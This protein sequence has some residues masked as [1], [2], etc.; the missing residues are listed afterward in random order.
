MNNFFSR[1]KQAFSLP[2]K[3][4]RPIRPD[5]FPT[6]PM[7]GFSNNRL[8]NNELI[9]SVISRLA[10]TLSSLPLKEFKKYDE[11]DDDVARL[12]KFTAN[13]NASAFRLINNLE[14]S[15]NAT[16]NGF[17]LIERDYLYQPVNIWNIPAA[18]VT[19]MIDRSD[20]SLW[21]EITG[22]NGNLMVYNTDI[23]H[24][25]HVSGPERILGISPLDVLKGALDFDKA[26]ADFSMS[27]MS[28]TDS[29][30]LKYGANVDDNKRKSVI[31]DF[32]RFKN[33]N[34]GVLFNEP[35]VEI[36]K[37]QRDFV[38]SD[39]ASTDE[40]TRI[41]IANAF[42]IPVSFL[43]DLNG[44]GYASNE[45]LMTQFVQMTLLP[46]IRQYET[47]F[48]R[49]LLNINQQSNG[50][51]FKFNVNGLLRGDMAA[52]TSYYQ[53]M[54]RSGSMTMNDVRSLEDLPPSSDPNADK[55]YISGDLYPIDMDPTQRKGV[56]SNE[57]KVSDDQA[58]S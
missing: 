48:N 1:I 58:G 7:M 45:Q 9:F 6:M 42:N 53:T 34:G 56:K 41:R 14:V 39:I 31:D 16:G 23:I 17:A 50:F 35:G 33:D 21:Y 3:N 27:E 12:L 46:I 49:K 18:Y 25:K 26:V 5:I 38:A 22:L 13:P 37:I 57:T 52:R 36:D 4:K 19:P 29:F 32:R 10:N 28:K 30:M 20:N 55:L 2:P 11:Q 47:E 51:Y 24:V 15:R 44:Q 40:T 54:I 8:D 43:N